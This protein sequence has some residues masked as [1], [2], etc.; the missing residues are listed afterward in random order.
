MHYYPY[1]TNDTMCRQINRFATPKVETENKVIVS[2]KT[3]STL[4]S[5]SHKNMINAANAG[6]LPDYYPFWV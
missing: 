5:L 4:N 3:N 6:L 2:I 1:F